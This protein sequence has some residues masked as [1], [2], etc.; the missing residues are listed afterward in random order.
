V[1]RSLDEALDALEADREFLLRGE[2]MPESLI[3]AY[4]RIKRQEIEEIERLPHPG[5]LL[6]EAAG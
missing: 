3:D 5:E 4:I 2:V 6:L 1:C